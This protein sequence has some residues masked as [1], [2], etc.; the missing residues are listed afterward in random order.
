[1]LAEH[2]QM[3]PLVEKVVPVLIEEG[4]VDEREQT[5]MQCLSW[6]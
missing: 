5:K 6:S 2:G 4:V 1:M 3:A